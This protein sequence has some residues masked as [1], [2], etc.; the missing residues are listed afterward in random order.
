M[1]YEETL[2]WMHTM[3]RAKEK[4]TLDRIRCLLALLGDPQKSLAGRFLHVTGTNGKGSV[5]AFLS[6]VLCRAGY[7]TGRFISPF[8]MEFTERME[9][10]GR[11][12][13]RCEVAAYG[14][15][16][17][18]AADTM[19]A[20]RGERPIE[21]ELVTAMGLLWFAERHCDLVVL[22]VGIG[23]AEDP[24]NVVVP[25]LSIITRVDFDH[26]ELLGHTLSAIAEKKAGIIKAGAPCVLSAENGM[27]VRT[28]ISARCE[29]M[30]SPLHL[31]EP[32][33]VTDVSAVPG[34][35]SFSYR[36]IPYVLRLSGLYQLR[37]VLCALEALSLLPTLGY[38]V[39]P[40]D[41]REGLL[42][43]TFP[44]RFEVLR[45]SPMV[46]LDGAHNASGIDALCENIRYYFGGKKLL[47][48]CGMLRDK[49]P[50]EV[51]SPVFGLSQIAAAA[52]IAPPTPRA[53]DAASLAAAY[54]AHGIPA[55]SYASISDAL[56][57]LETVQRETG[58]P[59]LCF[60]S[61]YLAGD[62]RRYF[63]CM[64]EHG[65]T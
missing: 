3:P 55:Q 45:A 5:C 42:E 15:R 61:L 7:R 19:F 22:E 63:G 43:T 32:D 47:V 49:A 56:S 65:R 24:T 54:T 40:M 26:M 28:V 16:L 2:A 62:V 21:F 11:R 53:M 23:G 37:N 12:I 14:D 17:R 64:T 13:T 34:R 27:E 57:V 29:T 36:G 51:L 41:I 20:Q 1:T 31:T 44:A 35:L 58:A 8:I 38:P 48:L 9:I 33:A 25:L 50:E 59:I 18:A 46:I 4:P 10:G 6:R 52:C 30:H 60:G 39:S